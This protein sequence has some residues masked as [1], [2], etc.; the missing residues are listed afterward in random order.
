MPAYG[1]N[2]DLTSYAAVRGVTLTGDLDYLRDVGTDYIDGTYWYKFK[3]TAQTD[4]NAYPRVGAT[5]VP[6][7][8]D[9]ATYEAAMLFDADSAALTSGATSNAGGGAV[10]SEKVDVIAV[11]YH[12]ANTKAL[13]DDTVLDNIPRYSVIENILRPLLNRTRNGT[14]TGFVV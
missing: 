6:E 12:A 9:S 13:S 2:V 7:R 5:V 4:D 3:G 8:V 11:S 1:T 10:A 14:A